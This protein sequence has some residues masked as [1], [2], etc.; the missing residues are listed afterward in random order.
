[1]FKTGEPQLVTLVGTQASSVKL[2][3]AG[4]LSSI[5]YC[6]FH[7]SGKRVY[8]YEEIAGANANKKEN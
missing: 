8:T 3:G 7:N 2:Y 1:L 5:D 4:T 6:V